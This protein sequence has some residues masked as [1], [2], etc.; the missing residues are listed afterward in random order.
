[1]VEPIG[2]TLCFVLV[3]SGGQQTVCL[4]S[5]GEGQKTWLHRELD[6]RRFAARNSPRQAE[7]KVETIGAH[8]QR[9]RLRFLRTHTVKN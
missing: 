7:E 1:M 9:W 8:L 6:E 3:E 5:S 4:C 2:D